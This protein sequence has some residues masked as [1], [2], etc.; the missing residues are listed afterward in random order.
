[1]GDLREGQNDLVTVALGGH[2][3]PVRVEAWHEPDVRVV[4]QV[5]DPLIAVEI[6]QQVLCEE[7]NLKQ[8]F[9]TC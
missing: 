9:A 7:D 5:G 2:F 4:D 3:E 1:V 8:K 6:L